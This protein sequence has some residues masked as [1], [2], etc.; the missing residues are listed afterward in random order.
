MGDV[1]NYT[2]HRTWHLQLMPSQMLAYCCVCLAALRSRSA[3]LRGRRTVENR[4]RSRLVWKLLLFGGG[5]RT[6]SARSAPTGHEHSWPVISQ[7]RACTTTKRGQWTVATDDHQIRSTLQHKPLQERRSRERWIVLSPENIQ[8]GSE[9]VL[10][11]VK[12]S[13][14]FHSKPLL[15]NS[16]SFTSSS[17]MKYLCQKWW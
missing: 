17:S 16:A 5:K 14:F 15:D 8:E 11:S 12:M 9:N 2:E 10:T 4:A 13:T 6:P 3:L 1:L 7:Y